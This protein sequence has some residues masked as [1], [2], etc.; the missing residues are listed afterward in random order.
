M[1][2]DWETST[3]SSPGPFQ[4]IFHYK[5]IYRGE[6]RKA[7]GRILNLATWTDATTQ[8]PRVDME[9]VSNA[10]SASEMDDVL[11]QMRGE[12]TD[13]SESDVETAEDPR[14]SY[15]I[16]IPIPNLPYLKSPQMLERILR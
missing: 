7:L 13:G 9:N 14:E 10:T 4:E 6:H 2:R 5:A 16:A 1:V 11:G 8:T 3:E 15:P 12:G